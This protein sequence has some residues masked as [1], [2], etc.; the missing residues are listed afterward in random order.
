MKLDGMDAGTRKRLVQMACV[1][2]WSDMDI[3]ESE[4]RV[5]LDLARDVDL[6]EDDLEEVMG[7][8]KSPPPDFDPYD[9]PRAHRAAFL[10]ALDDV[11]K[12]DGRLDPEE[13]ETLRLI[14]ELVA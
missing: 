13:C 6:P 7:W 12:A 8:L 9:I 1:A 2:A 14:K 4:R 5:V 11:V 3:A 10:E